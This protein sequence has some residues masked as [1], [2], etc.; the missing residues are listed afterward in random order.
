MRRAAPQPAVN[1]GRPVAGA[2]E[3]GT[4]PN[5][6]RNIPPGPPNPRSP[7]S[8]LT[9]QR[10]PNPGRSRRARHPLVIAGNAVLER[11]AYGL[12]NMGLDIRRRA[13]EEPDLIAQSAGDHARIVAAIAVSAPDKA[14]DAMRLH[15]EH[16][17]ASTRRFAAVDAAASRPTAIRP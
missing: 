6:G 13:T 11:L 16:I 12:Y 1:P 4:P 15:L 2:T 17:K 10:V 3:L 14:A 8:A 7:R 5:G 9:P